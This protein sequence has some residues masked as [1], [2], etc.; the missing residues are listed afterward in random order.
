MLLLCGQARAFRE[1]HG[2]RNIPQRI[3]L[4]GAHAGKPEIMQRVFDAV[5]INFRLLTVFSAIA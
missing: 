2:R 3:L 4:A 5:S 1:I